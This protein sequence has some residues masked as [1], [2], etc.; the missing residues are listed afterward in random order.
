VVAGLAAL[1]LALPRARTLWNTR[2]RVREARRGAA[3][4]SDATLLYSRM[5]GLLKRRGFQKPAW[6]TPVEFA[7]SL[8]ASQTALLL[9]DFTQAYNDLRF[10]GRRQAARRMMALLEQLQTAGR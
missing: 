1:I 4:P 5:L 3:K 6:L 7:H 9:E 8:P 2:Q 10:G